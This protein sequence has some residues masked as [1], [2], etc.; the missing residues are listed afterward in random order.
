MS[1]EFDGTWGLF[2]RKVS[3]GGGLFVNLSTRQVRLLKE[4]KDQKLDYSDAHVLEL[5][6]A[7]SRMGLV[8]NQKGSPHQITE[9]GL[10]LLGLLDTYTMQRASLKSA[11]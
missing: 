6:G 5:I 4:V 11:S 8:H 10:Q 7:L 3:P 9:P 2:R 1:K